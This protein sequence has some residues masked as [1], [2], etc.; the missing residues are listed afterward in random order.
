MRKNMK[1]LTIITLLL[2]ASLDGFAT[3][4][5][6]RIKELEKETFD[7]EKPAQKNIEAYLTYTVRE[8]TIDEINTYIAS[9]NNLE[10]LQKNEI[11][12]VVK[13]INE[14]ESF[15][16]PVV[17]H[18]SI[19]MSEGIKHVKKCIA[20]ESQGTAEDY[21]NEAGI[22]VTSF[23]NGLLKEIEILNSE[24]MPL[25]L[26]ACFISGFSRII[27]PQPTNGY[28]TTILQK[29]TMNLRPEDPKEENRLKMS[30]IGK[31]S[32]ILPQRN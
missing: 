4:I 26:R 15:S 31:A 1:I 12:K 8:P 17:D 11:E 19:K 27:Y 2:C 29:F 20:E 30:L 6:E 10:T 24:T 22:K 18:H 3:T 21:K 23:P 7:Q 28:E 9:K 16:L 13:R 5:E 14:S 25:Y 32:Q